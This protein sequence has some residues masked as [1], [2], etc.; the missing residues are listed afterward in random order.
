MTGCGCV[1]LGDVLRAT[2]TCHSKNRE[3]SIPMCGATVGCKTR[4]DGEPMSQ[5]YG[6]VLQRT[7]EHHALE[8]WNFPRVH[9]AASDS[10][11]LVKAGPNIIQ[12]YMMPSAAF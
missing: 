5:N 3:T 4:E 12:C 6:S 1:E 8:A 10:F 7:T 2:E 9:H 11:F